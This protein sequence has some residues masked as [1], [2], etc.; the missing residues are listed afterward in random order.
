[1]KSLEN[2]KSWKKWFAWK[3][4]ITISN[5]RIWLKHIYRRRYTPDYNEVDEL[6][7]MLMGE[8]IYTDYAETEFDI[9]KY[10]Q[11]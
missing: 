1:M 3:P 5:K 9:V 2:D 7:W 4:V 11:S 6:E 10:D 8:P